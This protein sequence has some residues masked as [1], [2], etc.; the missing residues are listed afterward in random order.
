[1]IACVCICTYVNYIYIYLRQRNFFILEVLLEVMPLPHPV[2]YLGMWRRLLR[3]WFFW[4]LSRRSVPESL[5]Q[6]LNSFAQTATSSIVTTGSL[7]WRSVLAF[8]TNKP[9]VDGLSTQGWNPWPHTQSCSMLPGDTVYVQTVIEYLFDVSA[10]CVWVSWLTA[11]S[12]QVVSS[13]KCFLFWMIPHNLPTD[14]L[15]LHI[16]PDIAY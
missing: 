11:F 7:C 16:I 13:S 5:L 12:F 3:L 8:S 1:M 2:Q 6:Y 4:D 9:H 15:W 10:L 14:P